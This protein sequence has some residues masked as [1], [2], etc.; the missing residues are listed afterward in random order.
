M[1]AATEGGGDGDGARARREELRGAIAGLTKVEALS[2]TAFL[3]SAPPPAPGGAAA[4]EAAAATQRAVV[5][6]DVVKP[7]LSAAEPGTLL[8]LVRRSLQDDTAGTWFANDRFSKKTVDGACDAVVELV[9]PADGRDIAKRRTAILERRG[10]TPELYAAVTVPRLVAG[11][12]KQDAWV[13]NIIEGKKEQEHVVA[14]L[15]CDQIIVVKDYKW[16]D[17]SNT[18]NLYYLAMFKDLSI[19][20]L[21]DLRGSRHVKALHR[22]RKEVI[23]GLAKRHGVS[24]DQLLAYV[25]YHP[26]FWY[27]HVH[28]VSCKHVMFT[29]EGSQNLLLSAMDRFHKLDTIIALL[30]A[31]SEYYASASLPILL[32]AHQLSWYDGGGADD[33][34]APAEKRA[35]IEAAA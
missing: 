13:A 30:E 28:I 14:E 2:K 25:H 32:P 15:G 29:G 23:P 6:V 17:E 3:L 34:A 16:Q 7:A 5:Q 11:A 19:R 8:D 33:G 26:T 35:R 4:G 24:S 12:A 1:A 22:L 18:D 31:N 21:R 20:S 27:F 10:E 9:Y